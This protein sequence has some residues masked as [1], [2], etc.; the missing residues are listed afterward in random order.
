[1]TKD[2]PAI[3]YAHSA[4]SRANG[5]PNSNIVDQIKSAKKIA[6]DNSWSI[7]R[8]FHST[9]NKDKGV[10]PLLAYLEC[11]DKSPFALIIQDHARLS[12]NIKKLNEL[13]SIVESYEGEIRTAHFFTKHDAN[14]SNKMVEL[15]IKLSADHGKRRKK[16]IIKR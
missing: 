7:E 10:Q 11:R 15:I 5:E 13:V 16:K 2:L 9:G 6:E 1:M 3:I 8:I 12:R 4:T 14:D